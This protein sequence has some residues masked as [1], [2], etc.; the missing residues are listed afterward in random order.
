M[1]AVCPRPWIRPQKRRTG[2]C[3]RARRLKFAFFF[4]FFLFSYVPGITFLVPGCFAPTITLC[5]HFL[6]RLA[7]LCQRPR[8]FVEFRLKCDT[9]WVPIC[10]FSF[11]PFI[12]TEYCSNIFLRSSD[13][14]HYFRHFVLLFF[15]F[16]PMKRSRLLHTRRRCPASC[17]L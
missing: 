14:L 4:C 7:F 1:S 12:T 5:S 15:F 2:T 16:L 11:C 3:V 10:F 9:R 6:A 17:W 8:T 13:R